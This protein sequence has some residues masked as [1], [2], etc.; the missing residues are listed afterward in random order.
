MNINL[1]NVAECI[2]ALLNENSTRIVPQ[3]SLNSP[4]AVGDNVQ[5]YL[6]EEGL[7]QA[8]KRIGIVNV[9]NDFTRRSM[10]DIA[11]TDGQGNYYAVDV[12]THNINTQFNRPN[13]ISVQRLAKFYRNDTN[14]FC[15]LIVSYTVKNKT[16]SFTDCNFKP[17]E[18]FSWNGCL[19][20]G[21]LGWGQIQIYDANRLTFYNPS[22]G[23]KKWMLELC[24][25]LDKFY[26]EEIG[27]INERKLWFSNIKKYW[28]KHL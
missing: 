16:I 3:Q 26:D 17:I 11:F 7:E 24:D 8:L 23:R 28:E 21:A 9:Q 4:R 25:T 15:I 20:L 12:K 19:T 6:A 14:T 10:E 1:D 27:K 13:L 18:A 2:M 22:I 5:E